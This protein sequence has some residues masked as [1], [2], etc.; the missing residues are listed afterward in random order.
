MS[1]VEPKKPRYSKKSPGRGG[2]RPNA[3]RRKGATTKISIESLMAE[4]EL[5]SGKTW[6]PSAD[7]TGTVCGT[8]TK[9]L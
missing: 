4:I 9:P 2:A 3:G 8:T 7:Q 1:T 6:V 5:Q